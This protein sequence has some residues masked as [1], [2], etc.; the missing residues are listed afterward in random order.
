MASAR[1]APETANDYF[2]GGHYFSASQIEVYHQCRFK[3][4]CRYGLGAKERR[5]AEIDALEYGSLMHYLFEQ[6]LGSAED[7]QA[8]HLYA[9]DLKVRVHTSI[10]DYVR[11]NMGGYDAL[12]PREKYRLYRMEQTAVKLIAH[13]SEEMMHSLF[14]PE[15]FEL[16][17]KNGTPYPPL[18]IP[19]KNGLVTVG[20]IIDRVDLYKDENGT[21]YVRVVDYKTGRKEFKLADVLYGMS[22]QMLIYLAALAQNK[23]L[24]PAGILY[25]PAFIASVTSDGT[26]SAEKLKQEVEKNLRMNGLLLKDNE[27]LN[28][29]EMGLNGRFIPVYLTKTRKLSGT[30]SALNEP[31]L[32][33][34]LRYVERLI[35][36]MAEELSAGEIMAKPLMQNINACAW[37]PYTSVCGSE[38]AADDAE[39]NS[40]KNDEALARMENDLEKGSGENAE[41]D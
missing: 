8:L 9:D 5:P 16:E 12:S 31:E 26:E 3:Y 32:Q 1:L 13:M 6:I 25:M 37:C 15:H 27:I 41:L 22:L 33:I 39:K 4:F 28:A 21:T 18:R 14:R 20:G 7:I 29:M 38:H 11:E 19:T 23:D 34:V 35:A 30:A 24:H 10:M 40:M 2:G 17:L 36:T